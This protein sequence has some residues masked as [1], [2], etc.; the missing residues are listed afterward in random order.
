MITA[1]MQEETVV[2]TYKMPW[3][4]THDNE[5]SRTHLWL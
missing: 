3:P 4:R 1:I 2:V 5:T